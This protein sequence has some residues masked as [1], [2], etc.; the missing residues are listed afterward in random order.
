MRSFLKE[1]EKLYIYCCEEI[2]RLKGGHNPD[3]EQLVFEKVF[4]CLKYYKTANNFILT[5]NNYRKKECTY[6][7]LQR[8]LDEWKE[9]FQ[10]FGEEI[11]KNPEYDA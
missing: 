8:A 6:E 4:D 5:F 2:E 9:E 10:C 11:V 3:L 1:V 7:D